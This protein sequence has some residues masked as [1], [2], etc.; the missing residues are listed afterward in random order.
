M[1]DS[2]KNL[3]ANCIILAFKQWKSIN[4]KTR[5]K[6]SILEYNNRASKF[7]FTIKQFRELRKFKYT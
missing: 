5:S 7:N 3:A 6:R 1:G 4:L 2:L